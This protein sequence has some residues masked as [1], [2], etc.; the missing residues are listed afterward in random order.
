MKGHTFKLSRISDT[1]KLAPRR[2]HG[3]KSM[4]FPYFKIRD[5]YPLDALG[6]EGRRCSS[7][8]PNRSDECGFFLRH[9]RAAKGEPN[10]ADDMLQW[11]R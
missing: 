2:F 1:R 11:G 4:A 3:K 10:A 8:V 9:A 7:S 6:A 5:S